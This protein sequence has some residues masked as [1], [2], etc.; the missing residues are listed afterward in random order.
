M[1]AARPIEEFSAEYITVVDLAAQ[2]GRLPGAEAI[3]QT[4]RGVQPLALDTRCDTI[5][6]RCDL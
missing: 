1:I 3:L 4:G 2:S 6:R 5:F